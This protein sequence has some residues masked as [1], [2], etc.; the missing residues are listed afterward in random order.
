YG[1]TPASPAW[2]LPGV[3]SNFE[4]GLDRS[5]VK[6]VPGG[7]RDVAYRKKGQKKFGFNLDF[8]MQDS[9]FPELVNSLLSFSTMAYFLK[10]ATPDVYRHVGCLINSR[11]ISTGIDSP[12]DVKTEVISQDC[13]IG[14]SRPSGSTY[15]PKT[16]TPKMWYDSSVVF[17]TDINLHGALSDWSFTINNNLQRVPVIRSTNG[18]ML[19]YLAERARTITG[20][21]T[22]A[23]VDK[24]FMNAVVEMT[25]ADLIITI[26]GVGAYTLGGVAFDSGRYTSRPPAEVVPQRLPFTAKTYAFA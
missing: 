2:L 13:I 10:G 7:S 5:T 8:H 17:G 20:E 26:A 11:T 22:V 19:L 9:D 4:N 1:T 15:V 23:Y 6:I 21:L 16:T 18:D 3:R 24:T 25:E 12:I 14:T